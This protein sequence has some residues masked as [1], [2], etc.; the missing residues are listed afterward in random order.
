VSA[1]GGVCRPT[2]GPTYDEAHVL[3]RVDCDESAGLWNEEAH[4]GYESGL[5]VR[6]SRRRRICA[7]ASDVI[8]LVNVTASPP[9]VGNARNAYLWP[10]AGRRFRGQGI[11]WDWTTFCKSGAVPGIR[12]DMMEPSLEPLQRFWHVSHP[13]LIGRRNIHIFSWKGTPFHIH[14]CGEPLPS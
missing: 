14:T 2:F 6:G 1:Q 5:T 7:T 12:A 4:L 8:R 11:G 13:D 10:Y 9:Q 3:Q